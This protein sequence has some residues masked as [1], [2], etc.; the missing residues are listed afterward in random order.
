M[1]H[2]ITQ[3]CCNDSSCISVCPVN[4]I[5][6]TP[7]EPEFI[8]A[9]MLY[10]DP[11]T[12][13]DCGAC[14]DECPVE[15]IFP[16]V[17]L[18]EGQERYLQINADYYTDHDVSGGLVPPRK[19]APLPAGRELHVAIVG[20]GPA[21]F[22]AAEE[23]VKHSAIRVDMFD[24][25]P[26]PYGLVRAG[27]APDHPSTKG[28]EKTFAS[29]AAKRTFEYFLN[30][31]IGTHINHDELLDHYGAVIYAHG[32]STDKH[33]GIEG[34]DLPGSIAA[35]DFVAWYNGHPDFSGRDFDLSAERAVVVGNGNV[36]LDV[37]RILLDD[38]DHLAKTDIADH[39]LEKLRSS[40][41][42][43]VV[44]LGR[45]GIAQAAYTN[46]EFLAMGDMAGVDVIV[47]PDELALDAANQEARD[48]GTLDS[49]IATKV[50]IAEEF[51]QRAPTEGN[52]KVIF[53]Y[54]VSPLSI[55]GSEGGVETVRCARN[56]FVDASDES[57]DNPGDSP[58]PTS[59]R[60]AIRPTGEEFDLPAGVVMRAIG[61]TGLPLDGLPFDGGQGVVPNDGGR[62][63]DSRDGDRV[64]GVYVTGWIKRGAT[65]G[66][67][68]NRLCGQ[69]TAMAVIADFTEGE[70]PEPAKSREQVPDL[71][72]E[73][74]AGRIDGAGW[75][76]IDLAERTAGKDAGRRRIK[77]VSI[78]AMEAAAKA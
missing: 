11:D 49:T 43:E 48:G 36:A 21:G 56:E 74:G 12:C 19:K 31:E 55:K 50:R 68:M 78:E 72:A 33:L 71:I 66:I 29:T 34:E 26:T 70:L 4:C 44:L 37:A 73:R 20:A 1:T 65:G 24:R 23:L 25:L 67:G 28:V 30:V 9:E 53:R 18:D 76:N 51:A 13:I 64:E 27:V 61:Y 47:D 58:R 45:R 14:I 75:K 7:D 6:P 35:T 32:A 42:N 38:P 8:S 41:I 46:S 69:E 3:P 59:G 63:L 77:L 15:A 2:V 17:S 62:V 10:I 22:Y 54:L 5:H 39:A 16:D 52:K 40:N 57:P 60:V